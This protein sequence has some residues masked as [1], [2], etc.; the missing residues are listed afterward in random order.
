MPVTVG[1]AVVLG[2]VVRNLAPEWRY[3]I[4][5]TLLTLVLVAAGTFS[6]IDRIGVIRGGDDR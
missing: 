5:I 4:A 1:A 3:T 2:L 6:V